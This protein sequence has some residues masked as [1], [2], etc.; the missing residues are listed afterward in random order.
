[1]CDKVV[2]KQQVASA[3]VRTEMKGVFLFVFLILRKEREERER[4]N[5]R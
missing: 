2:A 3:Q 4:K 1:M 5:Y